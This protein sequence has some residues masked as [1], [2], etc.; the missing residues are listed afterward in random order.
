MARATGL[1]IKWSGQRSLVVLDTHTHTHTSK[2]S[3]ICWSPCPF[4]A[5]SATCLL[6]PVMSPTWM[7]SSLLLEW[8][9]NVLCSFCLPARGTLSVAAKHH[10]NILAPGLAHGEWVCGAAHRKST[11]PKSRQMQQMP[12]GHLSQL[13]TGV[14]MPSHCSW[15]PPRNTNRTLL[16]CRGA[17][18]SLIPPS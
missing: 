15:V 6:A 2:S 10:Q 11:R 14:S 4:L 13:P 18:T 17:W 9:G 7:L 12:H 16:S 5:I 8:S 3:E 1:N